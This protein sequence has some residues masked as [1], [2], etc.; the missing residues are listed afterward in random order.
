MS[1]ASSALS[2]LV[3]RM[4]A[5]FD[6]HHEELLTYGQQIAI[7]TFDG[8][9]V[10]TALN[11]DNRLVERE[12]YQRVGNIRRCKCDRPIHLSTQ[13][14]IRYGGK[15]AFYALSNVRYAGVSLDIVDAPLAAWVLWVKRVM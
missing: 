9:F 7:R 8:H 10:S 3:E 1:K 12:T 4:L 2:R 15:V 5:S 14:T 13:K 6:R 11:D